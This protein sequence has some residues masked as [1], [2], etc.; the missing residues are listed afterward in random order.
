[1]LAGHRQLLS[2]IPGEVPDTAI[3]DIPPGLYPVAHAVYNRLHLLDAAPRIEA[4][5]LR[6]REDAHEI[7]RHYLANPPGITWIDG[8]LSDEALAALRRHCLDSTIW[9]DFNHPNGYLGATFENGFAPPLLL[10]VVEELRTRFP[11]IFRDYPLTQLWAFKYDSRQEGIELHA[12]IAAVNLNFWITPDDANLDP[13]S[14]GLVVWDKEAPQSW[15][16]EEFNTRGAQARIAEFLRA[17]DAR[18]IRVPYRCNRAVLFNSDLFHRTD[19]IRFKEGY[20]NRR[21]NITM[22]FGYRHQSG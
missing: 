1:M 5:A 18:E 21:I 15:D 19:A 4:G 9:F 16:F 20:A 14:G 8:L 10:Q 13:D 12:D 3:L 2:S 11:L 7:E 17:E 6:P 22:L